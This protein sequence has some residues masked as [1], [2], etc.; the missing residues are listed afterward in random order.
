[1]NPELSLEGALLPRESLS[2][3]PGFM[4]EKSRPPHPQQPQNNTINNTSA[5]KIFPPPPLRLESVGRNG[6]AQDASDCGLRDWTQTR[7]WPE[8]RNSS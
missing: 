3:R 4:M 7:P 8:K 2:N 6:W 5:I 1:M